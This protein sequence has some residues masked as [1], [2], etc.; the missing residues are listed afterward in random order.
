MGYF[1]VQR[2]VILSYLA[3]EVILQVPQKLSKPAE[4]L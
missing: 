4:E 1:R 2:L 3:F